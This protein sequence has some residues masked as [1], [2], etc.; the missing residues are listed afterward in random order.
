M[1]VIQLR[2]LNGS[3][4]WGSNVIMSILLSEIRYQRSEDAGFEDRGKDHETKKEYWWPLD[5]GK[6][7]QIP[8]ASR[9]NTTLPA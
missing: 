7:K 6:R 9:R 8:R 3:Y 4:P 5:G 1:S 2:V